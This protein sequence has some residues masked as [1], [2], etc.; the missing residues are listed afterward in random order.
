MIGISRTLCCYF[1]PEALN[2]LE[3]LGSKV[4][5]SLGIR[6]AIYRIVTFG[7]VLL[8]LL[9]Y[10]EIFFGNFHS[11]LVF[12]FYPLPPHLIPFTLPLFIL[13]V[14]H[15]RVLN[16]TQYF[17]LQWIISKSV[18]F[19]VAL[20]FQLYIARFKRGRRKNLWTE[21]C[22]KKKQIQKIK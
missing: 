21:S 6:E 3:H 5:I 20:D 14:W 9:L 22:S 12:I 11:S 1:T 19:S 18:F 4:R 7:F 17:I 15:I 13:K 8:Y 16:A 10:L 2:F